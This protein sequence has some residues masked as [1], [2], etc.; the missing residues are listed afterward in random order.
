MAIK[1]ETITHMTDDLTGEQIPEQD[2]KPLGK[3]VKFAFDGRQRE[4]DLS[5]SN[6]ADF[7]KVLAKYM[8]ASRPAKSSGGHTVSVV[9]GG[10]RR[11][12][13]QGMGRSKDEIR[14]IREWAKK[15]GHAVGES[16]MIP[17]AIVAAYDEAMKAK[18][19]EQQ[20]LPATVAPAGNSSAASSA[21]PVGKAPGTAPAK[22]A[23]PVAAKA[24]SPLDHVIPPKVVT[25]IFRDSDKR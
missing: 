18:N 8:A 4:I 16:G 7:E 6:A 5:D 1:I 15:N 11:G 2:G 10:R 3:T 21:R 14:A 19:G 12:G 24:T 9:Q 25:P 13:G 22:K 23:E 20:S 17:K